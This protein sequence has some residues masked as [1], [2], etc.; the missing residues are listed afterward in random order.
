MTIKEL[1][2]QVEL[3]LEY[4]KNS[5]IYNIQLNN[6]EMVLKIETEIAETEQTLSV[7]TNS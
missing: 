3:R 2:K 5:R 6:A 4:L 1:I 7:L